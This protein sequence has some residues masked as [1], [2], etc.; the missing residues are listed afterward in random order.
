[1]NCTVPRCSFLILLL[2]S[3]SFAHTSAR[4][5]AA[6]G[7]TGARAPSPPSG[8]FALHG[9]P[10]DVL[11][12]GHTL[13]HCRSR[14]YDPANGRWLQ[15]DPKGYADGV[16]LYEAF[17][18]NSI[19]HV[20]PLGTEVWAEARRVKTT[21]NRVSVSRVVVGVWEAYDGHDCSPGPRVPSGYNR[22]PSEIGTRRALYAFACREEIE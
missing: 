17:H 4:W 5:G 18:G 10:V 19:T 20:D 1:M 6:L 3:T 16:D 8:T 12:D 7:H 11:S 13:T 9:R 22:H 15:R 21:L 2:A 14:T